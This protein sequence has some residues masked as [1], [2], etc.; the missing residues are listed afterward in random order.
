M[1]ILEAQQT[2][3][4]QEE[5][6]KTL[7]GGGA[8]EQKASSESQS[9]AFEARLE[10]E[11]DIPVGL[12]LV[13]TNAKLEHVILP[14][15]VKDEIRDFIEDQ[16]DYQIFLD[17]GI[18]PRNKMVLMGPPGN[19]KTQVTKAIANEME[20]PLYFVRYDM[21][22]S[23][24]QGETS[25]RLGVLFRFVK[26]H[27]CILFFDEIDAIG[28]DRGESQDDGDMQRVVSNLLVQ[29]DDVPPHV[30][31]LGATN[32]PEMLDRAIWRRFHGR[33]LLPNPGTDELEKYTKM[34]FD[35]WG[36]TP[37]MNLRTLAIT[38]D[39]ENFA[40]VEVFV[41]NCH[42][43][44]VRSKAKDDEPMTIEQ[45]I[46]RARDEWPRVRVKIPKA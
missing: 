45:A 3:N 4:F 38:L 17:N 10:D 8:V 20:L 31:V 44:F 39:A 37:D 27:R 13:K 29:L 15:I 2:P 19:G 11:N 14:Q 18:T 5:S 9:A 22:Q 40:E 6:M 1:A 30:I 35:K 12:S 36:H 41:E 23:T 32:H 21:L 42:R 46:Q 34:A 7:A 28:K 33:M 26:T 25:K 24:K 16:N 43:T